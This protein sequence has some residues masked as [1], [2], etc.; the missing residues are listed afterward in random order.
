M[1]AFNKTIE[2]KGTKTANTGFGTNAAN[3]GGRLL[4]QDGT[5]NIEKKGIG[6]FARLSW[7]HSMLSIS[8]W[9]FK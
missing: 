1:M 5:P 3:Y 2:T 4:N 8:G 9:R 6:F 7:F